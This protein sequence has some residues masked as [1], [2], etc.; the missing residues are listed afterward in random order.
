MMRVLIDE[1]FDRSR[2]RR[3]V[4]AGLRRAPGR[5]SRPLAWNGRRAPAAWGGMRLC[6]S[7]R[8]YGT[9]KTAAIRPCN[10]GMQRP[11]G[12]RHRRARASS[13]AACSH[14]GVARS[15]RRHPH[16]DHGR[17]LQLRPAPQAARSVAG[18]QQRVIN[19]SKLGD[20][21]T[22]PSR[23]SHDPRLQQQ[24][25]RR[26]PGLRKRWSPAS[27][28]EDLF[29]VV[30][31]HLQTDTAD[32][33]D[34]LLPATQLEHHDVH[35]SYGASTCWRITR[36]SPR[37]GNRCPTRGVPP[38]CRA[39]GVR[40]AVL[41]HSDEDICRTAIKGA[42]WDGLERPAAQARC[43]RALRAVQQQGGFPTP[44]GKCEFYGAT[45]RPA[46]HRAAASTIR[47]KCRKY[48]L[49]FLSPR[50]QLPEFLVRQQRAPSAESEPA[51]RHASRR[52]R[53]ARHRGRRPGARVQRW[54]RL[55]ARVNGKPPGVVVAVMK[56]FAQQPRCQQPHLAAHQ[57]SG[58]RRHVLRLPCIE[59]S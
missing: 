34:I 7:A 18:R 53:N 50:A 46:G 31:D 24:P 20:A 37:Q 32:Y 28:R 40:R 17:L 14:R 39:H 23:R 58:R 13:P 57:R 35:K 19:H 48:P 51:P 4:H 38:A 49:A 42:D 10:Y 41:R 1:D 26:C 21:L 16:A 54:T 44:S 36:R 27:R 15:G 55:R 9:T 43:A 30:M 8:E 47:P 29:T 3:Q 25:G 2:L 22:A 11:R 52:R 59:R 45:A 12:R 56:I 6:G 5:E 33:A